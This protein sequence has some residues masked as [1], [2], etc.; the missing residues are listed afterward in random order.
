[1]RRSWITQSLSRQSYELAEMNSWT[2]ALL[3]IN[4]PLRSFCRGLCVPAEIQG[5]EVW[6]HP[7]VEA[8]PSELGRL[9]PQDHKS[10][11]RRVSHCCWGNAA[12]DES[13]RTYHFVPHLTTP[14]HWRSHTKVWRRCASPC[15]KHVEGMH[16]IVCGIHLCPPRFNVC[17]FASGFCSSHDDDATGCKSRFL[18]S[19]SPLC[20]CLPACGKKKTPLPFLFS[21]SLYTYYPLH[22]KLFRPPGAHP[23]PYHRKHWNSAKDHY[24][25]LYSTLYEQ[26]KS[27]GYYRALACIQPWSEME[28][29][30]IRTRDCLKCLTQWNSQS[31]HQRQ[32]NIISFIP[33]VH[34]TDGLLWNLVRALMFSYWWV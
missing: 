29:R 21:P 14:T 28:T 10:R 6:W 9:S 4:L 32:W 11:R 3:R 2:T 12:P 23:S 33:H 5:R 17:F 19:L 30:D 26:S 27:V 15:H 8:A 31:F 20:S 18:S 34:V 25:S 22:Y 24:Y 13:N 16:R 7:Q 1:M